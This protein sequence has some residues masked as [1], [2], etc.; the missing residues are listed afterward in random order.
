[1]QFEAQSR[2]GQRWASRGPAKHS[3]ARKAEGASDLVA[4]QCHLA[5]GS[6]ADRPAADDE[7]VLAEGR[8][9]LVGSRWG[10]HVCLAS[11][12]LVRCA[13]GEEEAWGDQ[14]GTGGAG[15]S[16]SHLVGRR[17]LDFGAQG[18]QGR[19]QGWGERGSAGR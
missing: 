15:W 10:Q 13:L 4:E 9:H 14:D 18:V 7:H 11:S 12:L 2:D 5:G 8:G 3:Q 19:S 6:I 1:M 17:G 16:A